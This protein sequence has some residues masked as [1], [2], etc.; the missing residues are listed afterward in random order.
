[1][2]GKS[3][4]QSKIEHRL[5]LYFNLYDASHFV[6]GNQIFSFGLCPDSV[7]LFVFM[8]RQSSPYSRQNRSYKSAFL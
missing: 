8:V 5:E 2:I 4:L 7:V 3:L 6:N 1:M